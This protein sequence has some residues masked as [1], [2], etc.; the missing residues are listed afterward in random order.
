[1]R[2]LLRLEDFGGQPVELE[3]ELKDRQAKGLVHQHIQMYAQMNMF[4]LVAARP[5]FLEDSMPTLINAL[6]AQENTQIESLSDICEIHS[7]R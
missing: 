3:V 7:C 1:M 2:R 5:K 4:P 6:R